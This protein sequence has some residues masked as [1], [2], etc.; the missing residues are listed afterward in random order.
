[1]PSAPQSTPPPL[2]EGWVQEWDED[3]QRA[4]FVETRTGAVQ[5]RYPGD[6]G[7]SE[8]E[9][10]RERE[11]DSESEKYNFHPSPRPLMFQDVYQECNTNTTSRPK[12]DSWRDDATNTSSK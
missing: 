6:L 2:P 5:W 11:M 9:R 10:E 4:Y 12:K 1:M 7:Q 8:K 3:N